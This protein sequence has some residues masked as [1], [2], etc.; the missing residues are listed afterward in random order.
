MLRAQVLGLPAHDNAL[1]VTAA[2]GQ[3]QARLLFDCGAGVLDQLDIAEVAATDHLLF[4]HYHMDHIGG[5]D[6]Y[7]RVN[8]ERNSRENHVWGPPGSIEVLGH[9]FQGFLWNLRAELRGVWIV[10]ELQGDTVRSARFEAREGFAVA[11]DAGKRRLAGGPLIQLPEVQVWALPLSHHGVSL[12]YLLREPLQLTVDKLALERLGLAPG[13]WL[14]QLKDGLL[15]TLVV[16]GAVLESAELRAQ[17]LRA[18]PG[19]SLAY[20][21]DFLLDAA[22]M[23]RL[24]AALAG[25]GTLYAEAQYAPE[26]TERAARN[27]HTTVLQVAKLARRAEVGALRLL[28]LSRRYRQEDWVGWLP[29]A[30]AIFPQ[31]NYPDHWFGSGQG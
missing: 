20:L 3:S 30:R 26:D 18:R 10:H 2:T 23:D 7:F 13:P 21:S 28:H 1:L 4:S 5:F 9:R 6:D 12:G 25:V 27:H 24:A 15:D 8:F 14:A 11:H 16:N 22:E 17:L 29:A 31:T 19:D